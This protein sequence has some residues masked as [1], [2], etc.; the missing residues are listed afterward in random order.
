MV[1]KKKKMSISTK[2]GDKGSTSLFDG[3]RVSKA[4]LRPETYGTLD[5]ASAFIGLARAKTGNTRIRESLLK[6]Q[7]AIYLVNAELAC[8]EESKSGLSH[9][10]EEAHHEWVERTASEIERELD[11][12]PKFVLYGETEV[13]AVL[14]IARAVVRR[15]ERLLSALDKRSSIGNPHVKPFVNRLS[16]FLYLLARLDEK[17]AGVP[18][19]HPDA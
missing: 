4:S 14:D 2:T 6:I 3:T 15:A 1:E 9:R 13:G 19:R 18:P 7:N 8:P 16:D 10:F 17:E 5:E 12:P 11:L